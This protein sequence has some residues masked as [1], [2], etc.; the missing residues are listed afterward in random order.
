MARDDR[1]RY[2]T[3]AHQYVSIALRNGDLPK[4]DGSIACEDCGQPACEYDHRD[5]KKPMEVAPVCRACNQARGPGLHRDPSETGIK[6]PTIL[7]RFY[8]RSQPRFQA[9]RA[10]YLSRAARNDRDA[11]I[12]TACMG[13]E[14]YTDIAKR[15]D[16][17]PARVNQIA[18][19]AGIR[20]RINH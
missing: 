3:L 20:R 6:P 7:E 11:A 10:R 2:F 19:R 5:Y 12:V 4:L 1:S 17:T 15:Y 9:S 14:S 8:G 18:L 16:L 13:G